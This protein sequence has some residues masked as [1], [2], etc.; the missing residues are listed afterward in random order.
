MT[1]TPAIDAQLDRLAG[2]NGRSIPLLSTD[3]SSDDM[4]ETL[5]YLASLM[6]ADAPLLH[7]DRLRTIVERIYGERF[8]LRCR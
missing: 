1:P 8:I 7:V 5:E 3:F 2:P 4:L 6:P